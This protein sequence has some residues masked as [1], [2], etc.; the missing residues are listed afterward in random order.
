MQKLIKSI[1]GMTKL[2]FSVEEQ[3]IRY[4]EGHLLQQVC[5]HEI[6]CATQI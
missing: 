6:W 5:I 1:L 2:I 3:N 4:Q